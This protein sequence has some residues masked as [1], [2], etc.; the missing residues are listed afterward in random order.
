MTTAAQRRQARH[1]IMLWHNDIRQSRP[2]CSARRKTDGEQCQQLAMQNGKCFCHGGR[3]PKGKDWHKPRWPNGKAPD[4]EA[5]LVRK[6]KDLEKAGKKRAARL[7][8]MTPEERARY[9]RWHA[10]REPGAPG[11]RASRRQE[12]RQAEATR[13]LIH[14]L[15]GPVMSPEAEALEARI[16][17]LKQEL[18]RRRGAPPIDSVN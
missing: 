13:Q 11:P 7:A 9:D 2:K 8:A 10:T 14:R 3:T 4:A 18:A 17:E 16:A 15:A 6:L 1:A 5:K 12:M